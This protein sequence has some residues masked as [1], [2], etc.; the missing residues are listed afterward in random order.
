VTKDNPI[1]VNYIDWDGKDWGNYT[2]PYRIGQL[3]SSNSFEQKYGY[4]E[5]RSKITDQPGHWPA[6]WLASVYNW[7][8]EIDVYEIYTGRKGGKKSFSSNFHWRD[9]PK[10]MEGPKSMSPHRHKVLDVSDDFHIYAVEWN[11]D[12]FKVYYDNLLVRV[13]TNPKSIQFFEYPM[14]IIIGSGI[15][16]GEG[17]KIEEAKFP[18]Y[19]EI[20]YVRAYKKI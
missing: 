8:P 17:R 14:H 9:V 1:N 16:A 6:F 13:F 10:D 12:G 18:T 7:P 5:I 15:D 19:H 2:I 11:E 3:D 4:F 20:D